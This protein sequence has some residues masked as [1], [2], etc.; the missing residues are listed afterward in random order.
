MYTNSK[1]EISKFV[2]AYFSRKHSLTINR[3][4]RNDKDKGIK[5]TSVGAES[6]LFGTQKKKYKYYTLYRFVGL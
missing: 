2:D 5:L 4:N 1:K 3:Q 6:H